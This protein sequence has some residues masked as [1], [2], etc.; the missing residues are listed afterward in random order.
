MINNNP[1]ESAASALNI[2]H[3]FDASNVADTIIA[4]QQEADNAQGL[5]SY[6]PNTTSETFY[7][8]QDPQSIKAKEEAL[9]AQNNGLTFK[10]PSNGQMLFDMLGSMLIGYGAS[11]L[12]G[13]DSNAALSVGLGAAGINHDKDK[14]EANRFQVIKDAIAR[15]G[16]IYDSNEL[17]NFMKTGDGKG[18]EQA[19]TRHYNT[20]SAEDRYTQQNANREDSQNFQQSQQDANREQREAFHTDTMNMQQKNIDQRRED[21]K[22]QLTLSRAGSMANQIMDNDKPMKDRYQQQLTGWTDA[23]NQINIIKA[24]QQVLNS[25]SSSDQAKQQAQAMIQGA[26]PSLVHGVARGEM[27]GTATITPESLKGAL[28]SLGL[29]ADKYNVGTGLYNGTLSDSQIQAID[30]QIN[31]NRASIGNSL[32]QINSNENKSIAQATGNQNIADSYTYTSGNMPKSTDEAQG[33]STN[34]G[35]GEAIATAPSGSENG[36]ILTKGGKKYV[37]KNGLVYPV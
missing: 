19:E 10:P 12:L 30:E 17:Y 15:N 29:A 6:N 32:Q 18:M 31:G 23:K 5:A 9:R 28:P 16:Q 26:I 27:G 21:S 36:D 11:K 1:Y 2:S 7:N 20:Q 34:G 33:S 35:N 3:S 14:E 37:V 22:S 4:T 24:A 25:N 8:P 13:A